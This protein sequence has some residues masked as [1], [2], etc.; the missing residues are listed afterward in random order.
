[1]ENKYTIMSYWSYEKGKWDPLTNTFIDRTKTETQEKLLPVVI[2][3]NSE[4]KDV[5][6][7]LNG[8]TG[9]E[10]YYLE[11]VKR[12]VFEPLVDIREEIDHD[13]TVYNQKEYP[14]KRYYICAGTINRWPSCY[15]LIEDLKNIISNY[16]KN[17]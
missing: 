1:M 17:K 12:T 5:I 10:T 4:W 3:K 13:G 2:E 16:L 14:S 6:K 11:D 9:Y 8:P 7:F 15:V